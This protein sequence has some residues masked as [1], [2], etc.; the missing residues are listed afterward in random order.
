MP[1]NRSLKATCLSWVA[2]AG[3]SPPP[4]KLLGYHVDATELSLC[5]AVHLLNA[6]A[7]DQQIA[8]MCLTQ[9]DPALSLR[10]VASCMQIDKSGTPS[11]TYC[12]ANGPWAMHSMS[13]RVAAWK[14][15]CCS[16]C[17]RKP[18]DSLRHLRSPSDSITQ[19]DQ[20]NAQLLS[21]TKP[22]RP[23][24]RGKE[25]E[26]EI[27]V[28]IGQQRTKA[29]ESAADFNTDCA[30]P[31]TA[32]LRMFAPLKAGSRHIA[33]SQHPPNRTSHSPDAVPAAPP[34]SALPLPAIRPQA[35]WPS[36]CSGIGTRAAG[37]ASR[38]ANRCL[39]TPRRLSLGCFCRHT[40]THLSSHNSE[41]DILDDAYFELLMRISWS[42]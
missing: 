31:T 36:L 6:N 27:T 10:T 25:R 1:T 4:R 40:C 5:Q 19:R 22:S 30:N 37:R 3:V 9:P 8:N 39:L 28:T 11:S 14:Y 26:M 21:R 32:S 18:A 12:S 16:C 38:L 29:N 24:K 2:K 33:A 13:S 20:P 15:T 23:V 34:H 41:H 42:G 17:A 7:L 35:N